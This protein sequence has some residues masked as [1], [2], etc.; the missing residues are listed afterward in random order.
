MLY[1]T[2]INYSYFSKA[3]VLCQSLKQHNTD[4]QFVL[5]LNERKEKSYLKKGDFKCFDNIY[6]IDDIDLPVPNK[7]AWLF[8]HTVVELCTAIKPFA[9]KQL[10]RDFSPEAITYLDPDVVVYSEL[11]FFFEDNNAV[12]LTP[13]I[14][15]PVSNDF[16]VKLHEISCLKHGVFN[17]G[18]ISI[19]REF[20]YNFLD[21]WAK[22]LTDY[23]YDD[24]YNG[25]FTDQKWID[26]APC[27]FDNIHII[28]DTSYNVASWNLSTRNIEKIN[29]ELFVDNKK[30]KFF[31][32]S[33]YDKGT[34]SNI[35][36][37]CTNNIE[38]INEL[39]HLYAKAL[40]ANSQNYYK[41]I[42]WSYSEYDNGEIIYD[43]DRYVYRSNVNNLLKYPDP[44]STDT[45]SFYQ[46]EIIENKIRNNNIYSMPLDQIYLL[47]NT[48]LTIQ[49]SKIFI[50]LKKII[51]LPIIDKLYRFSRS[52]FKF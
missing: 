29:N 21:W 1:F 42:E 44:F 47:A 7:K 15:K 38:V 52:V 4:A 14:V 3:K 9:F 22:R 50:L 48:Y 33:G 30:I 2:S 17:L 45:F 20:G 26:L 18:F 31:H 25:I 35:S 13:H 23:C 37:R 28:K 32:F 43:A 10:F 51:R 27:I 24:L 40:D 49:R 8:S 41:K 39:S 46:V 36:T 12:L 6:F 34:H 5:V 19:K 16:E 11:K